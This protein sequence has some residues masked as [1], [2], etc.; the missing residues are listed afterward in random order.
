MNPTTNCPKCAANVAPHDY[1]CDYC[2]YVLFERVK[3][4][5]AL[6]TGKATFDQGIEIIKE[7]MNALHDIPK[8]SASKTIKSSIRLILALFTFGII[9]IF[10][11]RPKKRF[12]KENYDKL[13][14]IIVR[15]ISFLKISSAG[16]AD[17]LARLK[18]LEDELAAVDKQIIKG[19][20]AKTIATVSIVT[21]YAIWFI[22][23]ANQEPITHSTYAVT[24]FD[25]TVQGNMN[26]H[27]IIA[28][29]TVKIMHTPTGTYEEWECLIKLKTKKIETN[30]GK[31][32]N[33]SVKLKL[34]DAHGIDILG[35]KEAQLDISSEKKFSSNLSQ[36]KQKEYYYKFMLKNELNYAQYRDT[37][38]VNAVKFIIQI[39]SIN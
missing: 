18:V 10:W 34:T 19:I 20:Y 15:N 36:A 6:Q 1:V 37:L 12:V 28:S 35:F 17:L 24:P 29:D 25:T 2:G 8:P 21:L 14:S 9:L 16:S 22:Y 32:E 26:Q 5:D 7:N 27:I 4:T 31:I 38:P 13:K 3:S 39:D 33:Y 30:T 11:H 23:I